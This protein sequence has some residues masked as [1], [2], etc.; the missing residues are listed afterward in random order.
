MVVQYTTG[1]SKRLQVVVTD[2][3]LRR[4]DASAREQGLSLSEWVR[5]ALRS[6][7]RATALGAADAKLACV[8]AAARHA[9]PSPDIDEMNA[10]IERG[11]AAGAPA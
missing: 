6:A 11:Y 5:H 1:M 3:E 4:F 9:F 2:A 10:E 7:E 8:R